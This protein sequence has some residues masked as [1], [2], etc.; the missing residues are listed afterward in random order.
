[1]RNYKT[2]FSLKLLYRLLI[3][4]LW[5]QFQIFILLLKMA[6]L[7]SVENHTSH[8]QNHYNKVRCFHT[9][10]YDFHYQDDIHVQNVFEQGTL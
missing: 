8:L 2:F 5:L 4:L 7:Y 10:K 9:E 1:M 3:H 6:Y